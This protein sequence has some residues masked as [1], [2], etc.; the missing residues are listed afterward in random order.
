MSA[1]EESF[2]EFKDSVDA[3]S[4]MR[5]EAKKA[6]DKAKYAQF[7]EEIMPS[8]R[9]FAEANSICVAKEPLSKGRGRGH[10]GSDYGGYNESMAVQPHET[11]GND[12]KFCGQALAADGSMRGTFK[13]QRNKKK[14]WVGSFDI[15][16]EDGLIYH[17]S[18]S[19]FEEPLVT[20][21]NQRCGHALMGTVRV[22]HC[23]LD[24]D[25]CSFKPGMGGFYDNRREAHNIRVFGTLLGY[26]L[27]QQGPCTVGSGYTIAKFSFIL[28]TLI[29]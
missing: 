10:Y 26:W 1:K 2:R 20:L 11:P 4:L 8:L 21:V 9:A 28:Y 19:H 14:R 27:C 7:E 25:Q 18:A 15:K 13:T 3:E 22:I 12:G 23:I 24:G 5:R 16:G 29:C 6:D 17:A